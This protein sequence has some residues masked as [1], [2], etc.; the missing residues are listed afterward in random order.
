MEA[1]LEKRNECDH[2]QMKKYGNKDYYQ[3]C[4]VCDRRR[5]RSRVK[6]LWVVLSIIYTSRAPHSY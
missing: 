2:E 6:D 4:L 3:K 5:R 1:I